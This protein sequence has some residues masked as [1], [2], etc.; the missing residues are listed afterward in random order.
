MYRDN[1]LFHVPWKLTSKITKDVQQETQTSRYIVRKRSKTKHIID[2]R[3]ICICMKLVFRLLS[4]A[5]LNERKSGAH[6]VL[7]KAVP[8][9]DASVRK[10]T[11]AG[12]CG[13]V[14]GKD[15]Q[16]VSL[17]GGIGMEHEWA[18]GGDA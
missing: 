10:G 18:V 4:S 15:I 2:D 7:R 17:W 9:A 1:L 13:C 6:T 16:R 12:I 5:F 3:S 14:W 11:L 8:N